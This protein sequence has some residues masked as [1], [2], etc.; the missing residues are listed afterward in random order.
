MKALLVNQLSA[1]EKL[2]KYKVGALFM[3][4]GTGKSRTLVEL[5]NSITEVDLVLYIAPFSSINPPAGVDSIVDEIN[6]WGGF[7]AKTKYVG[8]ESIGSSDRIYLEM[9]SLLQNSKKPVILVD[10]SIKM[11]NWTAKR[12]RHLIGLSQ[13]SEYKLIA[14]ATYVT[15]DLLDIWAQMEF[16]SPKILKMTI[17]DFE[18]IFCVKT[19]ITRIKGR[20][21][22]EKEF[23]SGYEN[24]DY[25]Y[26]LIG[27]YIYEC[28]LD[29]SVKK[30]NKEVMFNLS[31]E[32]QEIYDNLKNKYLDNEFLLFKNNNIF[33]EMTQKMQHGYCCSIEKKKNID[34]LFKSYD[35]K[36]TVIYCKYLDSQRFCKEHFADPLILSYQKNALSINLQYDYDNIIFWDKIW[37][38]YLVKQA[39]GRID[40]TGREN[41]INY[42][43]LT[44]NVGLESL[45][46]KNIDK[47]LSMVEYFKKISM[48]QLMNDL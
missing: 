29:S 46:D 15:R 35:P 16:L 47:K 13:F 41:P 21:K 40:R 39:K 32:D 22:S 43:S 18:N 38:Y 26:N 9:R 36:R 12:T 42:I 4:T 8:V 37:D 34:I 7:Y 10:E 19:K 31:K 27:H 23:I 33:L 14:N 5:T 1:I 28:D 44:G 20:K 24:I 11:K 2:S 30:N 25:L 6:K 48:Q 3:D 17:A 45:I